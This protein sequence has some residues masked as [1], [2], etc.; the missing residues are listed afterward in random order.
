MLYKLKASI[1]VR[2]ALGTEAASFFVE[3][4]SSEK[5]GL[6]N[7]KDI[8]DGTDDKCLHKPDPC[9]IAQS[10]IIY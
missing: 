3:I 10:I 6:L 2:F 5:H 4:F 1:L 9:G 7:K 8:A